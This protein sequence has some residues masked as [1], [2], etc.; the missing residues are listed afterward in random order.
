MLL[1]YRLLRRKR[2]RTS[3]AR[4]FDLTHPPAPLRWRPRLRLLGVFTGAVGGLGA[5]VLLAQYGVEPITTRAIS[6]RGA[7]GGAIS[8]LVLPSAIFAVVVW[9][10]NRRLARGGGPR[11]RA[12]RARAPR[13]VTL[14]LLG[15]SALT[16][17]AASSA[18][19][20]VD[21]PCRAEFAGLDAAGR[22][23]SAGDAIEVPEDSAVTY[24]M[25]APE[26]LETWRFWLQYGPFTQVVAEGDRDEPNPDDLNLGLRPEDDFVIDFTSIFGAPV[27]DGNSIAG[28]VAT[29]EYAWM[30][31]GL[32][33]VHGAVT[34]VGGTACRGV[35]LIDVGGDPLDTVL[36]AAAAGAAAI[37]MAGAGLV[38]IGGLRDGG[39][40][41]DALDRFD[42]DLP[43]ESRDERG[44][45]DVD[46][47]DWLDRW[48]GGPSDN[49]LTVFDEATGGAGALSCQGLPTFSV[50]TSTRNLVVQD[51]V[52][53]YRGLGPPVEVRLTHNSAAGQ[54]LSARSSLGP[55]W[56]LSYDA[57]V[58][59]HG[60]L[61]EVR[62]GSGQVRR[63]ELEESGLVGRS[64]DGRPDRVQRVGDRWQLTEDGTDLV[65]A[66]APDGKGRWLLADVSDA[67]G[68]VV[69]IER[70]GHGALSTVTDA[71]GRV[72]RFEA[73]DAG[74]VVAMRTPDGRT[75]RFDYDAGGRLSRAV[76]MLGIDTVYAYDDHGRITTISVEGDRH[77]T[78]FDYDRSGALRSVTD[79]GGNTTQYET[80]GDEPRVV[81]VTDPAGDTLRFESAEGRTTAVED[82]AGV[83][84][85]F[86]HDDAGRLSG[87]DGAAGEARFLHD[88]GGRLVGETARGLSTTYA[89]DGA[90]RVVEERGPSGVLS[91]QRDE[92]GNV[93]ALRGPDGL[94]LQFERDSAGQVVALIDAAGARTDVARDA[95][96]N[97]VAVTDPLGGTTRMQFDPGG[98]RVEAILD[99]N[100]HTTR[101]EYDAN[102]RPTRLVRPDGSERTW[103][104]SCCATVA[105]SDAAGRTIH[106]RRDPLLR[107]VEET[108]PSG[109]TTSFDF[110]PSGLLRSVRDA[111]GRETQR[112]RDRAGRLV[113][114]RDGNGS[115]I[116]FEHDRR[117]LL[118][119]VVDA[120][121][122][123]T[124]YERDPWG[125]PV[126]VREPGRQ[127][128]FE[129]DAEGRATKTT[130][131]RGATV[132]VRYRHDGS[133][134][135]VETSQ[136]A[137]TDFE[138][139]AAGAV[140]AMSGTWGRT[141]WERDVLGRPTRSSDDSG[142]EVGFTYDAVGNVRSIR[143]DARFE[144]TYDHDECDRIRRISWPG[145]GV[146]L[147]R[148]GVGQVVS[149]RRSN[150][151]TTSY[152]Y[153]VDGAVV[154]L[155]HAGPGGT[156]VDL[157]YERD[158]AGNVV[159][160]DGFAPVE[161]DAEE[162]AASYD[163]GPAGELVAAGGAVLEHDADGNL[164][165]SP[166]AGW[167]ARFDAEN[168]LTELTRDGV[169][170]RLTYDGLGRLIA[171]GGPDAFRL[172]RDPSGRP[173]IRLG[174]GGAVESCYIWRDGVLVAEVGP[175]GDVRFD[176][177]DTTGHLVARTDGDG[178]V[179]AAWAY[180]PFGGRVVAEGEA[181][182]LFTFG[183]R[184]G[185]ITLGGGFFV[186]GPR[187]YHAPTGRF[188]QRD[189]LGLA[190]GFNL[191]GYADANPV[192]VI[193]PGGLKGFLE[194][195]DQNLPHDR[196][197]SGFQRVADTFDHYLG[198]WIRGRAGQLRHPI[199]V[200]LGHLE[201]HNRGETVRVTPGQMRR[202]LGDELKGHAEDLAD[203]VGPPGA[204]GARA[205]LQAARQAADG[206][207]QGM[208]ETLGAEAEPFLEEHGG[209]VGN[210]MH[211][212]KEAAEG[213]G[214]RADQVRQGVEIYRTCP[215]GRR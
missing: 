194:W 43:G 38:V 58:H 61:V 178:E 205:A 161:V 198:P 208:V 142:H 59:E 66:Y 73:D 136:G 104:Y 179:V 77:V 9:R 160:V 1:L 85:R 98:L 24:A 64:L 174:P 78:R 206:D 135:R 12:R 115:T 189:P 75:A 62:S 147:D 39:E 187:V 111:M 123:R 36:G 210:A 132:T 167:T 97:I 54:A 72:T 20:V 13:L 114:V 143:Y 204:S 130:N 70:L 156:F 211:R 116:R 209:A 170:A 138:H 86:H 4:R 8:G 81:V 203:H 122:H 140:V 172:V 23:T 154:G 197:K 134:A 128:A 168:L 65:L 102:G 139:D 27:V 16:L 34:T 126:V 155:T 127:L 84:V 149:E 183:G 45:G 188:L 165:G 159:A 93:I 169:T 32:Y 26:E 157:A 200:P 48:A 19:A 41:L 69:H 47:G 44:M 171:A 35:I 199:K 46:A 14:V 68:N 117:G 82:G 28:K 71:A 180:D 80:V 191:Y 2:Y 96:G 213:V 144:V 21:G 125:D 163:Y 88:A 37:G 51:T 33:E 207:F 106:L 25:A 99:A 146:D 57:E 109:A 107:V 90:G 15:W 31:A 105:T 52:F 196:I 186:M 7:L 42:G 177:H 83:A 30:G 202:Q 166:A 108:A 173:L 113:S 121:G 148:D 56:R 10:F 89:F 76:D 151:T 137:F 53:A 201:R 181:G 91:S 124:E 164:L 193:D 112:E 60:G 192:S 87:L 6:V 131:G 18:G 49:P 120:L 184:H 5:V 215:I 63:F 176:H 214:K 153:D 74:R 79:A 11:R 17:I 175:D 158:A 94:S 103:S 195:L 101:Y 145:G 67:N 95:F 141:R 40:L 29:S 118:T 110:D 190:G 182:H 152:R 150:G 133:T 3:R 129:F 22:T 119:A 185:V 92:R 162:A 50:N 100:G 212:V 55:G